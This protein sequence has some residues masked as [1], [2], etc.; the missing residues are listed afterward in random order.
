MKKSLL[1]ILF[2]LLTKSVQADQYIEKKNYDKNKCLL[3]YEDNKFIV[4]QTDGQVSFDVAFPIHE[5]SHQR[6]R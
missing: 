5:T 2:I 3:I 1:T 6:L 4:N